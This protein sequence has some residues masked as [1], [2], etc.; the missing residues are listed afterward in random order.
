MFP[1]ILNK[2]IERSIEPVKAT[3]IERRNE[4]VEKVIDMINI[5]IKE[6]HQNDTKFETSDEA[7]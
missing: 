5:D 1:F 2:A 3:L 6:L 7:S 4:I